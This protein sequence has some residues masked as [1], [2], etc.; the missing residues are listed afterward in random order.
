MIEIKCKTGVF[1]VKE[2][3]DTFSED[4]MYTICDQNGNVRFVGNHVS[5]V[6]A[7]VM[8]ISNADETASKIDQIVDRLNNSA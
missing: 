3:S 5:I 4:T 2:S 7:L 1:T 6:V 8:A